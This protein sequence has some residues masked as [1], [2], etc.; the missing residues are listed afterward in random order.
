MSKKQ[1]RTKLP[2]SFRFKPIVIEVLNELAKADIPA[3][4]CY[5]VKNIKKPI[6]KSRVIE[7]CLRT[8]LFFQLADRISHRQIESAFDDPDQIF[9]LFL[10]YC[11]AEHGEKGYG[12]TTKNRKT[13]FVYGPP[14]NNVMEKDVAKKW[15]RILKNKKG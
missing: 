14:S 13:R 8:E 12:F 15:E 7:A 6:P 4:P 1:K 11:R 10:M 9:W 5:G 2:T 3:F